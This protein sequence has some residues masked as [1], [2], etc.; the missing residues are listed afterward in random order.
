MAGRKSR[1]IMIGAAALL[2]L[3]NACLPAGGW[4]RQ[5][6]AAAGG[7]LLS[8]KLPADDAVRVPANSRLLMTFDEAVVKGSGSAGI[9]IRK[10]SDN[11]E[12]ARFT[13]DDRRV[14]VEGTR[15]S[16]QPDKPFASGESYY[17]LLDAGVFANAS[18]GA[19]FVGISSASEWNFSAAEPDTTAPDVVSASP[20]GGS[21]PVFSTLQLN[22]GEV[23]Y[24]SEGSLQLVNRTTGDA[25]AV[26]A[27]S[28]AVT[29]GGSQSL[30]IVPPSVLVPGQEY[31]IEVPAGWVQDAA[32]NKSPAYSW[33][34]TTGSSPV[35]IV[36]KQPSSGSAGVALDTGLR[37]KFDKTVTSGS[38]PNS[39]KYMTVK[40]VA[41]NVTVTSLN[42][43]GMTYKPDG[44][45]ETGLDRQ[46][47]GSTA[48][49]VLVDPGAFR[50]GDMLFAGIGSAAEWTFTT[51]PSAGQPPAMAKLEPAAGGILGALDGKLRITFDKNVFPGTGYVTIRNAGS[52]A[53]AATIPV[54]SELLNGFGSNVITINPGI[55]FSEGTKY[56]VEIGNQ[57]FLDESGNRYAGMSGS[58]AWPFTVNRDSTPPSI[59]S[60]LPVSGA[61]SVSTVS[62][63]RLV[64]NEAIRLA[65]GAKALLHRSGSST[66]TYPASL[67]IAPDNANALLLKP[68]AALPGSTQL[69][70]E[71]GVNSVT[72]LAGNG[73]S[74]ILNEYQW[75]FTT[76]ASGSGTPSLSSLAAAS[77]TRIQLVF[78]MELDS[79]SI[80]YPASFYV[81]VN[82]SPAARELAGVEVSGSTATLILRSPVLSGQKITVSY[83]VPGEGM[84]ALRSLSGVRASGFT[85]KEIQYDE[86]SS[87]P[88]VTSGV[89]NGSYVTLQLSK[90]VQ[91]LQA[92]ALSQFGLYV[93]GSYVQLTEATASGSTLLLRLSSPS[94]SGGS[95]YV[96]YSPGTAPVVDQAGNPLGAFSTYYVQNMLDTTKPV[97]GSIIAGG[98]T[99]TLNYNEGLHTAKVPSSSRFT[100][101]NGTSSIGV[102]G[103]SIEGSKVTLKLSGSLNASVGLTVSYSKGSPALADLAGNEADSFSGVPASMFT[104]STTP[105]Y[106]SG[107]ANGD[108]L[109][110]VY[111]GALDPASAPAPSQYSIRADGVLVPVNS[112]SIAGSSV[113]LKLSRAVTSG[114]A[115]TVTYTPP[116]YN[117]LRQIGGD[118]AASLLLASATN[119]TGQQGGASSGSGSQPA[120]AGQLTLTDVTVT[121]DVSPAGRAASRY[122]VLSDSLILAYQKARSAGSG[123]DKV[124]FKVPDGQKAGIVALPI[125]ALQQVLAASATAS[126]ELQYNGIST[127]IPLQGID[128]AR[129][130]SLLNAG[131]PTGYLMLSIDENPAT[132][133]G[134]LQNAVT[135]GGL[136]AASSVIGL[137]ISVIGTSA[138]SADRKKLNGLSRYAS[139]TLQTASS[140]MP[141]SASTVFLDD[142][143]AMLSYVPTR[144]S[145][146]SVTFKHKSGGVFVVVRG[147]PV[148]SDV[149]GHWA[150]NDIAA[151]ASKSIVRGR[152]ANSFMPKANITRAEFA[153][154]IARALGLKGDRASASAYSDVSSGSATASYV[155]AASAAGIV[156]GS[157]GQ[158]R[159]NAAISRQEMAAM[160]VRAIEASEMKIIPAKDNASYLA[161]FKDKGKIS[162]WAQPY[163]AKAVFA[164]IA[165]GQTATAFAP[166]GQATRAEAAV[167]IKRML[168]YL[169]MIDV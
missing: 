50:S 101:M 162:A 52:G 11:T 104:A 17:V 28:P 22:Y 98:N 6:A 41:D 67:S 83:S 47:A 35:G 152:S 79:G 31:R 160:M 142:E 126:F 62:P 166:L 19:P 1:T 3:A 97:L 111:S 59:V 32:G 138:T 112:V 132:L 84:P 95:A 133:A 91:A 88:K 149:N 145:G 153:E 21:V 39:P 143:T 134:G 27:V 15:V 139:T 90:P 42:T 99:V 147:T 70:V 121:Q 78:G 123:T 128:F 92:G 116:T 34:F 109:T 81:T 24:P 122:S 114:Q 130:A 102:S 135:K 37:L 69:Y 120:V 131:G 14:Q 60:M 87:L 158:F 108:T 57:A 119:A 85:G 9:S 150:K 93:N 107:M 55:L 63:L 10:V 16:I 61:T 38:T 137:D 140:L 159:P 12:W 115:V 23:V 53:A 76:M 26:S 7:P 129:T 148:L 13:A 68:D 96:N 103:V 110:L 151:L 136:Q 2:M 25:L 125:L 165:N 33:S 100:V 4:V 71:L 49:Y 48:Y 141:A 20:Q 118:S 105:T 117:P 113:I 43:S 44:T 66:Q 167:M 54:T 82:D 77:S 8:A 124:I 80:P 36:D 73:F 46:L 86:T 65:P 161:K 144:I 40:R 58:G 106:L 18:N 146:L 168:L 89:L 5:A 156:Q 75:K 154:Y 56:Y 163:A 169:G 72:D 51:R 29:G 45:V 94:T 30:T 157:G 127:V 164:G 74:G 64:F 155:G